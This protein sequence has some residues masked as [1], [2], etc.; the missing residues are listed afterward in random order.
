[1]VVLSGGIL[2]SRAMRERYNT[3]DNL[4]KIGLMFLQAGEEQCVNVVLNGNVDPN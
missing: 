4:T 1:M 3:A 2:T